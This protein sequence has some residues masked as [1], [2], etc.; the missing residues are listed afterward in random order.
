MHRQADDS[1]DESQIDWI[2]GET[3]D[4]VCNELVVFPD[5]HGPGV[6]SPECNLADKHNC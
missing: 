6:I 3:V 4:A 2:S 1:H 5:D